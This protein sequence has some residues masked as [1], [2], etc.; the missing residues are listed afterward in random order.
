M[1]VVFVTPLVLEALDDPLDVLWRVK[2]DFR[3]S[4][5]FQLFVVPAGYVTDL[6]SVPRVPFVYL[7]AGGRAR[8]AAVIHDWLYGEQ[9]GK[10]FADNVFYY[11]MRR[12]G[13][14]WPVAQLMYQA[15]AQFGTVAY[16]R[17]R[18]PPT[19]TDTA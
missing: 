15:V 8:K 17:K 13:I 14:S 7:V 11:A 5:D 18:E 10:G 4:V 19:V 3:V 16:D 12:E 6:A 1:N 9:R 2:E